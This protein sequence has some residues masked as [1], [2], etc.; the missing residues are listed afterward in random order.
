METVSSE[1]Y[2]QRAT[3]AGGVAVAHENGPAA[4]LHGEGG[5][6][7]RAW[8][9]LNYQLD[10][11]VLSLTCETVGYVNRTTQTHETRLHQWTEV[12]TRGTLA[13]EITLWSDAIFRVRFAPEVLPPED[14]FPEPAHRMLVE[15]PQPVAVTLYEAET[16]LVLATPGITLR[17]ARD[18]LRIRAFTSNGTLFW[19]QRRSDYFTAD[20][21][22]A[23]YGI[24]DSHHACFDACVLTNQEEIYGLGERFDHL[25]RRGNAVDFWNKDAIGTSSPRTYINVPFLLSTRG[26][27]LFVNM[28][29]RLDWQIGTREASTL[30]FAAEGDS[31]DYFVI[32]GDTPQEVLHR[33]CTL[34]GFAPT[35]PVWS[36]GLWMSRNSYLS[37]DVVEDV[38]REHRQRGIPADVLHLDTAWFTD[39]WNCDLRFSTERF[40]DPAGHML[41]LREQGFR[42][43]LWQYNFVPPRADNLNY[44]EGVAQG[45]FVRGAEGGLYAYPD[46]TAGAWVDDAIIDVSNPAAVEWYRE[47]IAALI[48]LGAATIKTD[49]GE[50]IPADGV[51]QRIA[52][53]KFHNLYSLVY[54]AVV[55][56]AITAVSGEHIVWA[57]SGTAGSQRYPVHWGGDSWCDWHSLS[58]TLRAALSLGLCGFPYFSHDIGGFIG[59]PTPELYIRWAQFGLFSSHARCH[60]AGNDNSREPWS[61][62]DEACAIFARYARLRYRLLPYIYQ[63]ARTATHSAQP[64]VRALVLEYP[65]DRNVWRIDDQYCFGDAFLVAP[66]LAPLAESAT[67]TLYLPAGLWYDYWTKEPIESRG[68][69]VTRPVDIETMPLYVKAGSIIPY[70]EERQY[71]DNVIGAITRLEAYTGVDGRLVYD[72]GVTAFRALLQGETLA[73]DLHPVPDIVPFHG[74]PTRVP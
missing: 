30:G 45:Y 32:A 49:F 5:V 28:N 27:G 29:A 35:P 63:Q 74:P 57:R 9:I 73:C 7:F 54:N 46:G 2:P 18:R 23:A 72:D 38:A 12:A 14:S 64:L 17:I 22:D 70:G 19:E 42:I 51:F 59:R 62:G 43:S 1:V 26:Y 55:A 56:E 71:T 10:G 44:L 24:L 37:W 53:R 40:P 16:E 6:L 34:T 67:R 4:I 60:G 61:F 31:L 65:H 36:F 50:G 48:R 41:R 11:A 47:Q 33:Y 39:D 8:R 21:L 68:E 66:V 15:T 20:V 3:E 58:G 13:V 69:W 25:S 52:G